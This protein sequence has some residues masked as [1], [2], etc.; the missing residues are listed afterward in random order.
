M[1]ICYPATFPLDVESS[2]RRHGETILYSSFKK[3]LPDCFSV[4]YSRPWRYINPGSDGRIR[5]VSGEVDFVVIHPEYGLVFVECK[6]GKISVSN[7][8][9][10]STDKLGRRHQI[11]NP[12]EQAMRSMYTFVQHIE[13]NTSFPRSRS[14]LSQ[15]CT[16]AAFFPECRRPKSIPASFHGNISLAGFDADLFDPESWFKSLFSESLCERGFR[17]ITVN[18]LSLIHSCLCPSAEYESSKLVGI[19]ETEQFFD[20]GLSPTSQQYFALAQLQF[21]P[22][23]IILGSAGTGKTLVG[24]ESLRLRPSLVE[25]SLFLCHSPQLSTY[26]KD[27]YGSS[28]SHVSFFSEDEFLKSLLIDA[29]LEGLDTSSASDLADIV[30]VFSLR[31]RRRY[32]NIVIDEMQDLP[33]KLVLS[34]RRLCAGHGLFLGLMD[35]KQSILYDFSLDELKQF[36]SFDNLLGLDINV[37]NTPQIMRYLEQRLS[38]AF[39]SYCISPNGL[40]VLERVV[41]DYR[42]SSLYSEVDYLVRGYGVD[43]SSI[44]LLLDTSTRTLLQD[45]LDFSSPVSQV[46]LV[47]RKSST[48]RVNCSLLSDYKGMESACVMLWFNLDGVDENSAYVAMTRAR[49]LLAVYAT[50]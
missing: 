30:D 35:P 27:Q 42:M 43:L 23:T 13:R 9:Y 18:E 25:K 10:I 41:S 44:V 46:L 45:S 14:E 17:S 24:L 11:K 33:E 8:S 1:A 48:F 38:P 21:S 40:D 7:D 32:Q 19:I 16:Y 29:Q 15:L 47:R 2:T 20:S 50:S 36:Y 39:A 4:Y 49:S 31:S 37:R 28:L 3:H 26:L 5:F 6:G 12:F 34:L 22:N